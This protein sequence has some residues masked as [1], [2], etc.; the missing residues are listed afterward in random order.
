MEPLAGCVCTAVRRGKA[1]RGRGAHIRRDIW[2]TES[3]REPRGATLRR[4]SPQ[5]LARHKM[6]G[7][8]RHCL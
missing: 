1:A 4:R 3:C 6:H 2:R 5:V 7:R 8:G